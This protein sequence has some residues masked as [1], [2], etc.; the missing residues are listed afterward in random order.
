[1]IHFHSNYCK[2]NVWICISFG[3]IFF[4]C[5]TLIILLIFYYYQQQHG[6][7]LIPY[8]RKNISQN[9][10]GNTLNY[11]RMKQNYDQQIKEL[12]HVTP[13]IPFERTKLNQLNR[14][15]IKSLT[16]IN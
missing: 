8:K 14:I 10:N 7:S 15:K 5:F 6:T 16:T 11:N 9:F 2:Q 1:M 13:I 3:T 12:L 4:I